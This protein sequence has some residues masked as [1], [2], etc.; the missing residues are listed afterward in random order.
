MIFFREH[1]FLG[2]EDLTRTMQMDDK[3]DYIKDKKEETW[4]FYKSRGMKEK[5]GINDAIS[6]VMPN[7]MSSNEFRQK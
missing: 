5:A 1:A 4:Y 3:S 7:E 2:P 6:V